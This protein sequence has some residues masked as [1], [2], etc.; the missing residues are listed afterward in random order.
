MKR[1]AVGGWRKEE[2]KTKGLRDEENMISGVSNILP[3]KVRK[4]L[5]AEARLP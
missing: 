1:K 2:R 4:F 3:E 5:E